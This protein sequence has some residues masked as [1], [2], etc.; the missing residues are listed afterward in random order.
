VKVLLSK[1]VR[2]P[3]LRNRR[4]LLRLLHEAAHLSGLDASLG[5]D[6]RAALQV[7]LVGART[8][9]RLN[10][11]F[12]GHQGCT[13]VL[14]FALGEAGA[15]AADEPGDGPVVVGE[16]YICPAVAAE[17]ARRFGTSL[18]DECVL[19]AVHGM[20][21]LAG[22]DDTAPAA[23]RAMRRAERRLLQR[24][25]DNADF[26]AIFADASADTGAVGAGPVSP[27]PLT[28]PVRRARQHHG[29]TN[30]YGV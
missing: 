28:A 25:R 16:V 23:R 29:K 3:R 27:S 22:Y 26:G 24:L 13:D 17:A 6:P 12:L 4:L 11:A 2:L 21:H 5:R 14:A 19:Y 7:V 9:A 8:M 18:A 20:L 1:P 15:G 30:T 10:A